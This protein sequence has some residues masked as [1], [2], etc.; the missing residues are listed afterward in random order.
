MYLNNQQLSPIFA[1]ACDSEKIAKKI[2]A[3]MGYNSLSS[4]DILR[5]H[6][7]T[8]AVMHASSEVIP[9]YISFCSYQR[10][11]AVIDSGRGYCVAVYRASMSTIVPGNSLLCYFLTTLTSPGLE[12]VGSTIHFLSLAFINQLLPSIYEFVDKLLTNWADSL[13]QVTIVKTI[14]R[15]PDWV[16]CI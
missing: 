9:G 12:I 3:R 16:K 10:Y 15:C 5:Y 4:S 7:P 1:C 13:K 2:L 8:T 14:R 11:G 6:I